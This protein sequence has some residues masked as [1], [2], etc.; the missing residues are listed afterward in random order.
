LRGRRVGENVNG[1]RRK[2]KWEKMW[3]VENEGE[4]LEIITNEK[5]TRE[6]RG[7]YE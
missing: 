1:N 7:D 3:K 5:K 2:Q 6:R 4:E